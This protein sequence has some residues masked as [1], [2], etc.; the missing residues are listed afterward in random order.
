M[1]GGCQTSHRRKEKTGG[2]HVVPGRPLNSGH[3]CVCKVLFV[4]GG[5][6]NRWFRQFSLVNADE[7]KLQNDNKVGLFSEEAISPTSEV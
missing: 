5:V 3:L 6:F 2:P 1:W 7:R 4:R